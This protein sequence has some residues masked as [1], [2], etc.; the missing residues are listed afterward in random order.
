MRAECGNP[1]NMSGKNSKC[2]AKGKFSPDKMSDKGKL[3]KMSGTEI[4]KGF[5]LAG[6][7]MS[8]E[9]PKCPMRGP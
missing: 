6:H 4:T 1:P 5:F 2:P 8:G 7:E 3:S 9:I